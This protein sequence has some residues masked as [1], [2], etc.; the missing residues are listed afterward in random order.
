MEKNFQGAEIS[1]KNTEILKVNPIGRCHNDTKA[2]NDLNEIQNFAKSLLQCRIIKIRLWYGNHMPGGVV[3]GIQLTYKN[4]DNG[5]IYETSKR[6]GDHQLQGYMDYDLEDDEYITKVDV[7]SG[8]IV[9]QLT[10]YTNKDRMIR[11]GGPGGDFAECNVEGKVIV[12]THGGF[13]GHLHNIGFYLASVHDFQYWRRKPYVEMRA[14]FKK[15][16]NIKT[17]MDDNFRGEMES[18]KRKKGSLA[19]YAFFILLD[20]GSPIFAKVILY[21]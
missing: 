6:Y 8:G 14:W 21:I 4:L 7:R 11:K 13:G 17:K 15:N 16:K 2:F 18:R 5:K 19:E 20:F 9:D 12:G 3:N 10:F 1:K